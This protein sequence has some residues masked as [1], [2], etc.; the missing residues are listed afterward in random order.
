MALEK[1]RLVTLADKIYGTGK[2]KE[3][4]E[5]FDKEAKR[6]SKVGKVYKPKKK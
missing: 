2:D 4:K 6:K 1:A 3:R 5:K